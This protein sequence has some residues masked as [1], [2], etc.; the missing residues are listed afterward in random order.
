MTV[1][2]TIKPNIIIVD[3]HLVFREGL[4]TIISQENIA[5]VIAEAS[6][7]LEFLDLLPNQKP[8]LVLMDIDMPTMNGLEATEKALKVMPDLKILIY[9]MFGD[10]EYYK[11]MVELGVAG[12]ILKS[13]NISE[14]ENA[15]QMIM[16]GD[17]YFPESR[18]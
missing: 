14:L 11:K 18:I 13:S 9:T 5:E 2:P 16:N 8:D 10:D 1:S 3:D 15:I 12:Y 17:K 4:R 6:N 7:G